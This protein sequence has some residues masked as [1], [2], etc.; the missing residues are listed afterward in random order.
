MNN[1]E[2]TASN[3]ENHFLL[4]TANPPVNSLLYFSSETKVYILISLTLACANDE[5]AELRVEWKYL[6]P[7]LLTYEL[8]IEIPPCLQASE[9]KSDKDQS[10][11][12]SDNAQSG[13][14]Q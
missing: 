12:N 11:D 5:D 10:G 2:F 8:H 6:Y 3:L 14:M 9:L 7:I 13:S 1:C 4:N